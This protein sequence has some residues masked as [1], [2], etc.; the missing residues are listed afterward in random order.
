MDSSYR[1]K[2]IHRLSGPRVKSSRIFTFAFNH[3]CPR[4]N[5]SMAGLPCSRTVEG[6]MWLLYLSLVTKRRAHV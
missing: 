5:I 2:K 1:E 4:T 3:R 6:D